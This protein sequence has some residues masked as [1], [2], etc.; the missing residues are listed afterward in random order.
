VVASTPP[1]NRRQDDASRP[2]SGNP[3]D[4]DPGVGPNR[5]SAGVPR[6]KFAPQGSSIHPPLKPPRTQCILGRCVQG[7]DADCDLEC[8]HPVDGKRLE[9]QGRHTRGRSEGDPGECDPGGL[10]R[11]GLSEAGVGARMMNVDDSPQRASGAGHWIE[12]PSLRRFT[13]SRISAVSSANLGAE[14]HDSAPRSGRTEAFDRPVVGTVRDG[15]SRAGS[16]GPCRV[17]V[18]TATEWRTLLEWRALPGL[19]D[20]RYGVARVEWRAVPGWG[21]GGVREVEVGARG[22]AVHLMV[23]AG[24]G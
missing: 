6:R 22:V 20:G 13:E 17:W 16:G 11:W 12:P 10:G 24:G 21:S 19:G 1:E 9:R 4:A 2:P 3:A 5:R 14:I 23:G 8:G 7:E 18:S 15:G